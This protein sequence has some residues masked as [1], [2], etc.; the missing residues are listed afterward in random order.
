M[1]YLYLIKYD[2]KKAVLKKKVRY[3]IINNIRKFFYKY[4]Y[5]IA[6]VNKKIKKIYYKRKILRNKKYRII[7]YFIRS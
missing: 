4:Y 6:L 2:K 7:Y 5:T 3:K 1:R